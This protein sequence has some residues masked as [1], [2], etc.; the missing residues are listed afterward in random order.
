MDTEPL[1]RSRR[2]LGPLRAPRGLTR[3]LGEA[4]MAL[5]LVVLVVFLIDF[6]RFVGLIE[7]R[8]PTALAPSDGLV[9]LTGGAERIADALDLMAGH[10][11]RRMLITGVNAN[12]GIDTLS[13][14]APRYHDL[15]S[16]CVDIDRN[17]LNTLGNALEAV[18]WAR[19][20]QF[21][22][23]IVVT[24]SYHMPRAM[25]ELSRLAPEMTLTP[26]PVVATGLDLENWWR[27]GQMRRVI[28]GEYMKYVIARVNL[29]LDPA[30]SA[31]VSQALLDPS[32]EAR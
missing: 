2:R 28:V 27:D 25:L 13:A 6:A 20:N 7:A 3:R 5:L 12:T 22:S 18:R 23:L 10:R 14:A 9:A 19:A 4:A 30:T 32:G 17:A 24:S 11:A 1:D 15:F 29:R 31:P 26:Y 8:E 16:C 21:H